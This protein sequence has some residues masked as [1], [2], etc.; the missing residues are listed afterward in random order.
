[1]RSQS[2]ICEKDLGSTAAKGAEGAGRAAARTERPGDA[3]GTGTITG[4][5][6]ATARSHLRRAAAVAAGTDAPLGESAARRGGS[7]TEETAT[8]KKSLDAR[9]Q[10]SPEH[11]QRR[12]AGWETVKRIQPDRLVLVDES[13]ASTAMTRRYG[14]APSGERIRQATPAGHGSGLP[15]L[16]AMSWQG[17]LASRTVESA[18]AGDVW[19]AYLDSLLCP[20]LRPGQGVVRDNRSA[21][22]VQRV[23][24]RIEAAG[25]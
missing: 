6:A 5:A 3:V 21:H 16:G 2:G 24:Q 18:T 7:A 10:D 4:E 8:P 15:L 14:R 19:L 9:E 1:M 11:P 13:G 23:R 25:A 12:P 20:A 22:Q 17:M